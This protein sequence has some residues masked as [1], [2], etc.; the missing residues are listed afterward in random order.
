VTKPLVALVISYLACKFKL[1]SSN[2]SDDIFT[3]AKAKNIRVLLLKNL[4][5]KSW[6]MNNNL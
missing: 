4:H 3:T 5:K 1:P 6:K 2:P